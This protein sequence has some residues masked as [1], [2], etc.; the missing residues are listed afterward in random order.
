[1]LTQRLLLVILFAVTTSFA[2]LAHAQVTPP[3]SGGEVS[4]MRVTATTMDLRFGMTGTGQGRV[5]IMAPSPGMMPI[6]LVAADGTFYKASAAFGQGSAVG[7]GYVVYCGTGH[8]V[9]VTGL[10]PSTA[11]YITTAEYNRD[12]TT[13]AYN[14]RS[15][16]LATYT[17]AGVVTLASP[18]ATE[19]A[20]EVY[21]NPSAGQVVQVALRGYTGQACTLSLTDALGR[22][23]SSQQLTATEATFTTAL[24]VPQQLASGAYILTFAVANEAP[25]RKQLVVSN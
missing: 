16:S 18:S 2:R 17:K 13:V 9:T 5:V 21:P 4:L 19:R 23:V 10:N 25:I 1:M 24:A 11:Y 3:N 8:A 22:Q 12:S 20:I 15:S 7:Q 14:T 6:P